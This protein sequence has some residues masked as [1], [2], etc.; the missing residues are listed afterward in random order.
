MENREVQNKEVDLEGLSPIPITHR[1]MSPFS[2]ATVMWSSTIIV[3][4]MVIGLYLIPPHGR[5]NIVQTFIVGIISALIV[6]TMMAL[7][8]EPGL[9]YGIPFVIQTRAAF[10]TTGAKVV[11]FIRSMP[12]ICWNGIASWIGAE[13]LL[14]ITKELFGFG[15]VWIYFIFVLVLQ[16][17]LSWN[18]VVSIKWFDSIVSFLIFGL[19]AYFFIAAFATGKVDFTTAL[20]FKGT[21][22]LAFIA[23][24]MGA[25]ANYTTVMLNISDLMRH[26]KPKSLKNKDVRAAG[27]FGNYVGVIPPWM[28]MFFSGIVISLATGATDPIQGL[29][30]LAPNK[31]FGVLV[32]VFVV[33]AQV[34]SNLTEDIVPPA[35]AFQDVFKLTWRQGVVVVTVL[36]VLTFPWLLFSSKYFFVYQNIY[37]SFLGPILGVLIADYFV[38]RKRTYNLE[39]LYDGEKYQYKRGFSPLACITMI[40]GAIV[41]FIFLNYSWLVGFPF[42]FFLYII[43]KRYTRLERKYEAEQGLK[44]GCSGQIS[45][46]P[47]NQARH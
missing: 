44:I 33:M 37:S 14:V 27:F 2:Y 30:Q 24:I 28:V 41:S 9:K 25:T 34:S 32:M 43:L 13:A 15:N 19:L 11:G 22:G 31:F 23:G 10:G 47:D 7:N 12:A 42:S 6:S 21:W 36:S 1:A 5:L 8:G 29:L 39:E 3:Q 26:V 38:F 35:M 40:C 46:N 20:N 17:I 18:G 45:H 16:A 4:I